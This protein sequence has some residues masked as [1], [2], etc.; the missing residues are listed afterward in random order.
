LKCISNVVESVLTRVLYPYYRHHYTAID[1]IRLKHTATYT[2]LKRLLR[3]MLP[4]NIYI[5]LAILLGPTLTSAALFPPKAAPLPPAVKVPPKPLKPSPGLSD[6]FET[7]LN[8]GKEIASQFVSAPTTTKTTSLRT[9]TAA[10]IRMTAAPYAAA[11]VATMATGS[12]PR[13]YAELNFCEAWW[14]EKWDSPKVQAY[15]LCHGSVSGELVF[16]PGVFDG[17]A[18]ACAKG[19]AK[20]VGF[21]ES[22]YS[23]AVA[24]RNTALAAQQRA[25]YETA[26][27]SGRFWGSAQSFCG[28]QTAVNGAKSVG[29][30]EFLRPSAVVARRDGPASVVA[31]PTAVPG[32]E[33]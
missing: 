18:A 3:K 15:C 11:P 7:L 19:Y 6:V 8:N 22:G 30:E 32:G 13:A 31:T 1:H 21:Y 17:D 12:C 29:V 5:T 27:K 4:N 14:G 28:V 16:V 25:L 26:V 24:G 10:P 2:I 20:N 9:P 33:R 23:V